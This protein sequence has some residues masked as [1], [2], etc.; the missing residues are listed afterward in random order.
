MKGIACS[1]VLWGLSLIAGCSGEAPQMIKGLR[2]ARHLE[3]I[4]IDVGANNGHETR[5]ALAHDRNV[6]AVE[7]LADAYTAL[8]NE[9]AKNTK[10]SVLH[11]CAGT[12]T[13]VMTLHLADDS[14][15]L[16]AE[17][18]AHGAEL[19]KAQRSHNIE[20]NNRETVVVAALDTLIKK[21]IKVALIKIDVQGFEP[22]VLQG[23]SR[24]IAENLPVLIYED[25]PS[26]SKGG[27]ITIP[28]MYTCET[29]RGDKVCHVPL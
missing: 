24:I 19:K 7:C 1:A 28:D 20:R 17:N 18:I 13:S 12:E 3:G 11:V 6:I 26:F 27:K 15:S 16:I 14:S 25:T 29:V 21:S 23:A 9:F 22:A 10:V 2:R 5:L 8:L 4:V